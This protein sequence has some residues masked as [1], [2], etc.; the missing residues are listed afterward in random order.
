MSHT[1]LHLLDRFWRVVIVLGRHFLKLGRLLWNVLSRGVFPIF[2]GYIL[3]I[4]VKMVGNN[5]KFKNT[6]FSIP[7]WNEKIYCINEKKKYSSFLSC[8]D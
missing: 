7:K 6:F 8:F 1:I 2:G 5:S 4:G 3:E